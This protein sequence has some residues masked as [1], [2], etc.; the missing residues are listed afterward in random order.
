MRKPAVNNK[1]YLFSRKSVL[2]LVPLIAVLLAMMIAGCNKR[3]PATSG[4]EPPPVAKEATGTTAPGVP[5]DPVDPGNPAAPGDPGGDPAAPSDPSGA[6]EDPPGGADDPATPTLPPATIAASGVATDLS[7]ITNK[8]MFKLSDAAK[9]LLVQNGFVVVPGRYREFFSLY[10]ANRYGPEPQFVTTDS[11]LH[12]Y[13]LF[14]DFLLRTIETEHLASELQE[15]SKAMLEESQAQYAALKGTDWE[16]AAKRNVGFFTVAAKLLGPSV[17][18]PPEVEKEVQTELDLIAAHEG[19][20]V[21]PLMNMGGSVDPL[22]ALKEDYTQYIPR[23]HYD[24]NEVLEAY[25]KAMMWYGRM[26]F[27]LKSEDETRSAILM[28]L[29]LD[30]GSNAEAW[31]RIYETT[32]FFAGRSDDITYPQLKEVM[33]GVYG[34]D[35]DLQTVLADQDKWTAFLEAAGELAPPAINSIPIFDETIQPDREREIKGFRFM[36][37]R[38]SLDASIFQRL[39]YRDVKENPQG[40]RRML[41]KGLDIPAALG[42]EEAYAILECMG[43]TDYEMYPEN[44][45]KIR[46]YVAGLDEETWTRDLYWNWLYTLL[47]LTEKKGEDYPAFM[48]SQAWA[49]K[50][51]N[52][53]LGS[54]TE[55]KH[56]TILYVKQFYAEAGGGY[57]EVDDRGYVE[58]NPLVFARLEAL[59]R[60]TRE[61]LDARGLLSERDRTSLERLE[62]LSL[63]L[64]SMAEKELQELPLTDE[65]YNL[66]RSYGVQLEHFW[67][68]ALRDTDFKLHRSQVHSQPA[69]LVADVATDPTGWVLEEA[70]GYIDEIYVVVPVDG[71]LRIA[72]GGVFSYYE[73]TQPINGRLTDTRW[74]E[75]LDAG[76]A[77]PRP[78]WA[79]AFIAE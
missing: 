19:I 47:P 20:A 33:S 24:R 74:R 10:E 53:F 31:N 46:E 23:G 4:E 37:Q 35:V 12:T 66:I 56:D 28:V 68:E 36:G 57:E 30:R 76:M 9:E 62:Q 34:E 38:F 32:G 75:M 26:T 70:I 69:A 29:A 77:P 71:K 59:A 61:G 6:P 50:E 73:F 49:R 64:K 58:P 48:R 67:M 13:H 18:A 78:E 63:S 11:L 16:N 52:T 5:G 41:P 43:E 14:F 8:D 21:S 17:N 22:E 55:L 54:W 65:E 3:T 79:K 7:N 44:M 27:R 60:S 40:E 39:C 15:L 25:F 1:G 42:S 72:K 2:I 45:A 51:L